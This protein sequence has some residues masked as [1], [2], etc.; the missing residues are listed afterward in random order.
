MSAHGDPR[1]SRTADEAGSLFQECSR[2]LDN[3]CGSM[4]S[5]GNRVT[6]GWTIKPM[7]V[8]RGFLCGLST[9]L[10]N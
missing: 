8:P 5:K 7:G 4:S 10:E 1:Y 2:Q 9:P 3:D 6:P